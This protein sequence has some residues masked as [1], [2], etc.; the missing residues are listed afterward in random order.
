MSTSIRALF[1]SCSNALKSICSRLGRENTSDTESLQLSRWQD[2]LGRLRLWAA[3][4]GVDNH[5]SSL[6]I[7][8]KDSSHIREQV[9]NLLLDLG[10]MFRE[11]ED[12]LDLLGNE[13]ASQKEGDSSSDDD[14]D[15][16][17][18]LDSAT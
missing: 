13:Q 4:I 7:R 17:E 3:N 6:E 5:Q 1:N 8:L 9:A 12:G 15:T 10:Q 16:A 2:E 11:V 14:Y 18:E